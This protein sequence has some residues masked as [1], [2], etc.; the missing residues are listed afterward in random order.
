MKRLLIP[1]LSLLCYL[2][3]LTCI[4]FIASSQS[5]IS[6]EQASQESIEVNTI[7]LSCESAN[8][9]EN[10]VCHKINNSKDMTDDK[11]SSS[12]IQDDTSE[13]S[14]EDKILRAKELVEKKREE[15][16]LEEQENERQR[17]IERRKL[18]QEVI[19]IFNGLFIYV[20]NI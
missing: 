10:G 15:K 9:K 20:M 12:E 7:D 5:L 14:K 6:E 3:T 2:A 4:F 1:N 17:E 13:L 11:P 8:I 19:I 18:G 16:K